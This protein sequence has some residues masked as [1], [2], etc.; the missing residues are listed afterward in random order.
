[1]NL[2]NQD[3]ISLVGAV[4]SMGISVVVMNGL[5]SAAA[6]TQKAGYRAKQYL[7]FSDLRGVPC[8]ASLEP[9]GPHLPLG[10]IG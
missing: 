10:P 2:L 9:K 5:M 3:G 7:E 4:I 8:G 6:N 1:M